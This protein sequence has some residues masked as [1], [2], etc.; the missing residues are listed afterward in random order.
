MAFFLDLVLV[1]ILAAVVVQAEIALQAR[2]PGGTYLFVAG[3]YLGLLPATPLQATLGKRM[4]GLRICDRSGKRIGLLRSLLRLVAFVPSIG[5]A[6]A[7]FILAAFTLRRQALHDLAAGTFV[8]NRGATLEEIAQVPQPVAAMS[9]I[10]LV[11]GFSLLAFSVYT[12]V[13]A[14]YAKR[15]HDEGIALMVATYSYKVEVENA[16]RA[17]AP[18]PQPTALP[19]NA[20]AMSARPDGTIVVEVSDDLAPGARLTLRPEAVPNGGYLWRCRAEGL[21]YVPAACRGNS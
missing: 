3:L 11:L 10:G 8:V 17:G 2:L 12:L 15:G 1:T 4:V 6:G 9:R 7:G 14:L 13:P 16:L 21:R 5:I 19:R 20:R 18:M